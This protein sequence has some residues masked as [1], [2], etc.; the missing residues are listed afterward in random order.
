MARTLTEQPQPLTRIR[1][2]EEGRQESKYKPQD[3]AQVGQGCW[4][5]GGKV[6]ETRNSGKEENESPGPGRGRRRRATVSA[7]LRLETPKDTC[8]T[9]IGLPSRLCVLL[10][11]FC[12]L[13]CFNPRLSLSLVPGPFI[14]N[15]H[16]AELA[17]KSEPE[18]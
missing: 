14:A 1:G 11:H 15:R 12:A 3:Q 18:S 16:T 8:A 7:A 13:K 6:P 10:F 5:R 2:P 17:S 4:K 9:A